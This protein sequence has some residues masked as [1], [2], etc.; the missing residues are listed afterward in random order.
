M[1]GLLESCKKDDS[2]FTA[3]TKIEDVRESQPIIYKILHQLIKFAIRLETNGYA[4]SE[5]LAHPLSAEHFT[6]SHVQFLI[7]NY[8]GIFVEPMPDD[9]H[10]SR[11]HSRNMRKKMQIQ[12]KSAVHLREQ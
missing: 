12:H 4:V 10:Y 8:Q 5:L 3:C 2:V 9:V 7:K 6:Q 11:C 1:F